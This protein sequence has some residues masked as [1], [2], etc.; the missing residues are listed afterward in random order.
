CIPVKVE[1]G[2]REALLADPRFYVS[3]YIGAHGWLS[4]RVTGPVDWKLVSNLVLSS[5]RQ[6]ALKRMLEA[7]DGKPG[8]GPGKGRGLFGFRPAGGKRG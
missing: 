6:V 8:K 3:P 1:A 2:R 4:M 7:L 5:Y